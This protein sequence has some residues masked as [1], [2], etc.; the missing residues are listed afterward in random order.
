MATV[1]LIDD[2]PEVTAVLGAFFERAG[3]QVVRVHSGEHG[4]EAFQRTRPDLVLLDLQLPDMSG[5]DVLEHIREHEP[6]VIMVTGHGDIP[7]AV[8]ALQRGAENFLTKPVDLDHLRVAAER[9]LEKARLRQLARYM[10]ERRGIKGVGALLGTSPA[11]RELAHQ[12]E[13]LTSS[14]RTTVLLLGEQGTAKGQMAYAMHAMSDRADKPFIEVACA[15]ALERALDA[16]LFGDELGGTRE[17][18]T[19]RLGL[20]EVADKGALLLD[21]IAALELPVQGKLL[22]LLEAQRFRRA[23]GVQDVAVDVRVIVTSSRDLVEEVQA[24]RFRE[25]LY[26]RLSVLPVVLPPLRARA[27][28]DLVSLIDR[29]TS[30]LRRQLPHAPAETSEAA[31]DQLLRHSWPGNIRE[32]RNVLERAM[33]V[34][35]GSRQIA[36]EHLPP[37]VR[38]SGGAGAASHVPRTL[39]DVERVH[40]ERTLRAHNENRTRAARE[41]GISRAT[42]I[43]KLKEYQ[44]DPL[45]LTYASPDS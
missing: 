22:R 29:I 45:A 44:L 21:E 24:G 14:D 8:Q 16:E 2:T 34:G 4:I 36:I 40:I 7:L 3:H 18:P 32:L 25:D 13:L 1:L 39:H 9:G 6:V 27:R 26:Y 42:L 35:R 31:L 17:A 38:R 37:D 5:F 41:L 19:R 33:I 10:R 12:I 43:N 11:M 23:G 15:G 28:E 30:E 20:A